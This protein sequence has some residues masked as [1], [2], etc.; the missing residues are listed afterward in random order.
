MTAVI[1]AGAVCG[2]L[3]WTLGR[4][5]VTR[6]DQSGTVV[7]AI[8]PGA[9]S[10][11]TQR[12]YDGELPKLPDVQ[13]QVAWLD[14][15]K[16]TNPYSVDVTRR[17]LECSRSESADLRCA[18]ASMLAV[19]HRFHP[20]ARA[21]LRTLVSDDCEDVAE[22]ALSEL[23][24]T[25]TRDPW[26]QERLRDLLHSDSERMRVVALELLIRSARL[27][28]R[29][30]ARIDS[31]ARTGT[32]DERRAALVLFAEQAQGPNS[33][34][35]LVRLAL[36]SG[37]PELQ[38][39]GFNAAQWLMIR[40]PRVV[41]LAHDLVADGDETVLQQQAARYLRVIGE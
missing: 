9:P 27:T 40:D 23:T 28:E 1:S 14:A 38:T 41:E 8:E 12:P 31:L 2:V 25:V 26:S 33:G 19:L 5:G 10:V 24:V 22:A 39:T 37:M 11:I 3:G 20:E 16:W 15:L 4:G 36:A 34:A 29:T 6:P 30:W 21:R 18:S 32:L 7:S 35:E 17:V 13:A